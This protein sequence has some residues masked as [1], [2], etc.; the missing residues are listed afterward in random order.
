MMSL[1]TLGSMNTYA[2][3][4]TTATA[5]NTISG[6]INDFL[7]FRAGQRSMPNTGSATINPVRTTTDDID[8]D[9]SRTTTEIPNPAHHTVARL[10]LVTAT[11][12]K[13]MAL[14]TIMRPRMF[15]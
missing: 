6:G 7:H 15:L 13:L 11:S 2:A 14:R 1:I 4:A 9:N 10:R 12:R 3:N 8:R 5:P